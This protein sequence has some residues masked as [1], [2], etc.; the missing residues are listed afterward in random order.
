[1]CYHPQA[2]AWKHPHP[3]KPDP[4][5]VLSAAPAAAPPADALLLGGLVVEVSQSHLLEPFAALLR[6]IGQLADAGAPCP[7]ESPD[8][9]SA[10]VRALYVALDGFFRALLPSASA[11]TREP[12]TYSVA[13]LLVGEAV[14]AAR[15]VRP[16]LE[17]KTVA[18][19]SN[20][21]S[22]PASRRSRP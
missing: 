16:I 20:A 7:P 19:S 17:P 10:A 22:S 3:R 1:M 15:A 8:R 11:E 4:P 13:L 2:A 18:M 6:A 5:N 14:E 21:A 12:L 9:E